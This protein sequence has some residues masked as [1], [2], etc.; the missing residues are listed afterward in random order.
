MIITGT[1]SIN[2]D[3]ESSLRLECI[4]FWS[5][6]AAACSTPSHWHTERYIADQQYIATNDRTQTGNELLIILTLASLSVTISSQLG[7]LAGAYGT[8]NMPHLP[9]VGIVAVDV[10][11][12]FIELTKSRQV[13]TPVIR[14]EVIVV[15]R[16]LPT[17]RSFLVVRHCN[18]PFEMV[19][20]Y[21]SCLRSVHSLYLAILWPLY[22]VIY[23]H[24]HLI[25]SGK[26]CNP[27]AL[28]AHCH[29]LAIVHG[30]FPL[31]AFA[32][33]SVFLLAAWSS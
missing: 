32:A 22:L 6:T 21:L 24:H 11:L 8:I 30:W 12:W 17:G 9:L 29:L 23:L 19:L 27:F 13:I 3:D 1:T 5:S 2:V 4:F 28:F 31:A 33:W 20:S 18:A 7:T 26:N 14:E 10:K 16:S 15:W 25:G